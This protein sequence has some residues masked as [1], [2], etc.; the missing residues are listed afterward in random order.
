MKLD[1]YICIVGA[2][3]AGLASA[4]AF[5]KAGYTNIHVF[6]GRDR[7][8]LEHQKAEESYPIGIN[9]RGQ[10]A[11]ETL[12]GKA[13]PLKE[14]GLVVDR[15]AVQ[16]GSMNVANFPSGLVAG[17]TR[18]AVVRLL[19]DAVDKV[20]TITLHF[21][22]WGKAVVLESRKV[23]F[24]HSQT[25]G[26][27]EVVASK[28]VVCDGFKSKIRKS[29]QDQSKEL[30]VKQF[31]WSDTFRVLLSDVKG[32]EP[33]LDGAVHYI[34]NGIYVSKL[35][36]GRWTAVISSRDPTSFLL[37]TTPDLPK[38]K[39]HLKK[40][41]PV[42]LPLFSDEELAQYFTRRTFTGSVTHV[43]KL[44]VD[45]WAIL[46]GDAAHSPIPATGEVSCSCASC[47]AHVSKLGG[48]L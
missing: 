16:V 38:L 47:I 43:S 27:I 37:S 24:Q 48:Q 20:A 41:C 32:V 5:S 8:W 14:I 44:L 35:P 45:N 19:L 10:R 23:V 6:E 46:L 30:V 22:H 26:L 17:T 4:L 29:L 18:S 34:M 1:E 42:M 31:P 21:D 13:I 25:K 39:A 2:G 7:T 9:T 40:Q 12:L 33:K 11:L 15:W 28:L 3:P 36:D